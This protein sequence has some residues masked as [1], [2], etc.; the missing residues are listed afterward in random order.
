[1]R[2]EE[3][4]KTAGRIT[5]YGSCVA[6]DAAREME[7][8][9]WSVERYIAR[10]SLISAGRPADVGDLDLSLLRS[11][12]ARRS[13]LSDM[14]GN[15]EAQLT[16]AASYTDLL[17]WDLTDER[18]G[19]LET[20]P[21]TFLTRSTEALTAGLYEGLPARFLELGT[22]EHLHLWRPA[23]LRFHSLLERLDL[24]SRTILINVPWATRTTSG[25]PTVPSWGQT[26]MEA[27]WV[28]TR[29]VDLVRQETDLRILQVPDELVVADDA[30]RWGAAPFHYA[31]S[32]YSWV[33]EEL[34][35]AL[36]PRSLAPAL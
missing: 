3:S 4:T 27:N 21:G 33:A 5:V 32:L 22:A 16:A 10:Q 13:F 12:F 20:A 8:R 25:T 19:V 26:A 15:L 35:I 2:S 30:H 28:M 17:L 23:L 29:Y 36:A 6:R 18:L 9:G 14:V 24:A 34:E 1:M 11:S 7:Q 31:A